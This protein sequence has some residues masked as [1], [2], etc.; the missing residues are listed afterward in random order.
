M[1]TGD[2]WQEASQDADEV[3]AVHVGHVLISD[4]GAQSAGV[5]RRLG[6]SLDAIGGEHGGEVQSL[7]DR[8]RGPSNGRFVIDE[9]NRFSVAAESS[10]HVG[11]GLR[12][13]RG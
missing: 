10:V 1:A 8:S 12:R 7:Q 13:D 9:K 4:D 2:P 11:G 6:Q 3:Q 5:F